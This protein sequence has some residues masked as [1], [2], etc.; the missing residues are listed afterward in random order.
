MILIQ[1]KNKGSSYSNQEIT[2]RLTEA[3]IKKPELY[4]GLKLTSMLETYFNQM[5]K[6]FPVLEQEGQQHDSKY[7]WFF[8][9]D[10][11]RRQISLNL[12]DRLK[13]SITVP[14]TPPAKG[15]EAILSETRDMGK[16]F[17]IDQTL[18]S[19]EISII[20]WISVIQKEHLERKDLSSLNLNLDW[21]PKTKFTVG[22]DLDVVNTVLS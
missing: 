20:G 8:E 16:Y 7:F 14:I 3:A 10:R 2:T 22:L 4:F 9:K 5:V 6:F 11:I 1:F 19:D 17:V 21:L 18:I 15:F 12:D 13:A